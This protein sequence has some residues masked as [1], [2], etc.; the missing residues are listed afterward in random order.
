MALNRRQILTSG[1][2]L[3]AAAGL[4]SCAGLTGKSSS[5]APSTSSSGSGGDLQ[6]ELT[7]VNWSGDTEKKAFDAV[8]KA[9]EAANPGI[10]VKT[11][12]VPYASVQ[13]NLDSR[14]QAGNPPDL[15]RVSYIDIGQYTSQDVLLDVSGTFDQAKIDAFVPGLWQGVVYDGK[16]YGVPHQIDTT[17]ILYRKDSFEAAGITNIPTG[18]DD[19]WSWEEFADANRKLEGIVK[20][21]QSPFIY[22]WQSAGAYRWLSW[23]FQAGGNALGEDLRTPAIDSDAGRKAVEFTQSF[24]TNEWVPRNS[25]VKSATYPDSVFIAGTVAMAFAGDFLIPGIEDGVKGKF[26]YGAMPMPR[27]V[28]A[29]SDLGGNAIVAAKDGKNTEAAARFLEFIVT[30]EQQRTFCEATGQLPT[31]NALTTAEL[32]FAVQPELMK[33][34]V[35]QATTITPEQVRQVTVPQFAQINTALQAELEKAFLGGASPADTTAAL[36]AAIEKA[37][38]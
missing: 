10:T 15:F 34:F 25:S 11:E 28:N 32:D 2:G 36:A 13:T 1:L 21:K 31:L 3:G 30:E 24:F 38:P 12:T 19:A 5:D 18:L 17:A 8:I 7:F 14:F 16:P 29:A 27:D 26:E 35:E 4:S 6:A 23:L 33:T 20:G 22:D 9:F 37:A